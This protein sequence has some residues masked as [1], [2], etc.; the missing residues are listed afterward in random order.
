MPVTGATL[1]QSLLERAGSLVTDVGAL[2]DLL[3]DGMT[4]GIGGF[5]LDR[6]PMALVRAIAQ[7]P[8]RDLTVE[9]YAGGLDIELLLAAGKIACISSCHVGL[10][11]FGLAPLFRAARESGGIVFK[12]WSEWSQL[13]AWR[14]AA[15]GA[16]FASIIMDSQSELLN[17]NPDI[18]LI[19][20]PFDET[21]SIAVKAP[22]IDV[23]ILHAEAA[24]PEGWALTGGDAYLDTLLARAAGTVILSTERLMDDEE[25]ERRYR[26]VH[27]IGSYVDAILPVRH[28]ALPGSCIPEYLIDLPRIRQYVEDSGAGADVGGLIGDLVSGLP[29]AGARA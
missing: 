6:K 9:T 15:E 27:L 4:L 8:V 2:T 18:A 26:D 23:A 16:P 10:D 12:E 13:A 21:T 28:G 17:V 3:V 24:H 7:S 29:Q 1:R 25:L 14:A 11:H 20:S 19:P 5:G 22:N